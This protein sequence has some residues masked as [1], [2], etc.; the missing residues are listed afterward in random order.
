MTQSRAC[1]GVGGGHRAG[2]STDLKASP[3]LP[4]E[5]LYAIG[6]DRRRRLAVWM[7]C[8]RLIATCARTEG[9]GTGPMGRHGWV[10]HTELCRRAWT[11]KRLKKKKDSWV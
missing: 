11:R 1:V 6:T 8:S 2:T 5:K 10:I 3:A 9:G 4:I 7:R